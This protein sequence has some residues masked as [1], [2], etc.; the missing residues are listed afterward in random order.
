MPNTEDL[1]EDWN[2]MTAD[3][4]RRYLAYR[5]EDNFAEYLDECS[6]Q[7]RARATWEQSRTQ[8]TI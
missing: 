6:P 4:R 7:D 1:P 3:E 8:R 2:E 5:A